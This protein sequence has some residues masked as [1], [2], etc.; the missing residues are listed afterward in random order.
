[1]ALAGGG[2]GAR[3]SWC[4]EEEETSLSLVVTWNVDHEIYNR[5]VGLEA[6]EKGKP[7]ME[8]FDV[9]VRAEAIDVGRI[10]EG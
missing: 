5:N 10:L 7:E 1:M 2:P 6:Q 9:S 3:R 8:T 4:G